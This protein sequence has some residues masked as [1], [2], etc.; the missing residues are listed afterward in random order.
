MDMFLICL[1][2]VVVVAWDKDGGQL[3]KNIDL[4]PTWMKVALVLLFALPGL[5]SLRDMRSYDFGNEVPWLL[6][7]SDLPDQKF[8]EMLPSDDVTERAL[9]V[10]REQVALAHSQGGDVLFMDQ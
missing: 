5:Q 8:L 1:M 2:F 9:N 6:T 3:P 10:I 4:L 7:L